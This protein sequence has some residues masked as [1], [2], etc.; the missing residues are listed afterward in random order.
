[1]EILY[2]D[3]S[4]LALNK[5]AGLSTQSPPSFPSV[6]VWVRQFIAANHTGS[7]KP[8]LGVPHR[9]DRPVSGC[10]L[11]ALTPRAARKLSRQFE[12]RQIRKKYWT[13]VQGIVEPVAGTWIDLMRK[14]PDE[15]RSEIVSPNL[16][17]ARQA[18][19]HYQTLGTTAVG[20]WLEI[21]LETGR[22]HQIRLQASVRGHPV[23][24]DVMYAA[25]TMFGEQYAEA[26]E[27]AIALHARS[28]EFQHPDTHQKITLTAPVS[29]AWRA[30]GNRFE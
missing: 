6:E 9:L 18:V 21:E 11:F 15:P 7:D 29:Q 19:L 24:G 23:L 5:P 8:Y 4:I 2:H 12:R 26:R 27:R 1:M 10:I 3:A 13:L 16:P 22:M 25:E 30:F 20:S 17:D 28:I 14:V